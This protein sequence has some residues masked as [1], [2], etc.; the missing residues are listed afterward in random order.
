MELSTIAILIAAGV[1]AGAANT[2]AGGGTFVSYPILL[3]LGLSPIAANVTSAV[4]LISGY[5]GGSVSYRRELRGQGSRLRS[6]AIVAFVGAVSGALLLLVTPG[7]VFSSIV[8]YLVLA[9]CVLLMVQGRLSRTLTE[10]R[11]RTSTPAREVGVLAQ[12]GVFFGAVYG[13][14][15]GAG[16][17]VL[18]LAVL[19]SLIA[20]D[21]QRI[22][23]LRTLLSLGIKLVGV[24][25]FAFSGEVAWAYA[26]VLL[27]SAYAGGVL[28]AQI[29]R[30]MSSVVLRG[31]VI[32]CGLLVAA[33]LLLNGG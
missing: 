18:L 1:A 6:M 4:G 19:G 22:N 12:V 20:D 31:T 30:R 8:P 25:I 3:S 24:G 26:L 2:V 29:T 14:Y 9:A 5:A 15:F 13:T 33:L 27:P 7:E 11:T 32:A 16:V 28:G 23:G 10:S 21:L 17:G